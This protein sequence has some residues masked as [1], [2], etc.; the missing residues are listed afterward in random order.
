MIIS[1]LN[2]DQEVDPQIV[3]RG[4]SYYR[5]GA[6]I[7]LEQEG[8]GWRATVAGSDEYVVEVLTDKG[9]ILDYNCTCPY[10]FGPICKHEVAVFYSIRDGVKT[11]QTSR[12]K[13]VIKK[14][15]TAALTMSR[16][17]SGLLQSL[18][19]DQLVKLV[20]EWATQS[21]NIQRQICL[22]FDH[23]VPDK[24][25]LNKLI[26]QALRQAA[27]RHGFLDY[28][29]A[30]EAA[31]NVEQ[32]LN[33]ADE[34]I[35]QHNYSK[36]VPYYQATIE[37]V[38]PALQKADDSNGELGGLIEA[39]FEKLIT[40]AP[41]LPENDRQQLFTYCLNE[42]KSSEYAGWDDWQ[43]QWL[44]IAALLI[45]SADEQAQLFANID[46]LVNKNHDDTGAHFT[47]KA[48]LLKHRVINKI[49]GKAAALDFLLQ[50]QHLPTIKQK[51]IHHH[52]D[53]GDF[54][55]A[56]ALAEAAYQQ[57][58][59]TLS[60]L[61]ISFAKQLVLIAEHQNDHPALIK[62]G[63]IVFLGW[64]DFDYFVQMKHALNPQDWPAVVD[65]LLQAIDSKR[66]PRAGVA[67]KAK[68][69]YLE[70]RPADLYQLI[71]TSSEGYRL[72][73]EYESVLKADYPEGIAQ[74]YETEIYRKL[75]G[76]GLGRPVYQET[77]RLLRRIKK[78]G[79][80]EKV[81]TISAQLQKQYAN[82]PAL[83]DEL[84]RV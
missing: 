29:S 41:Q 65:D 26:K 45:T 54:N 39:S 49:Q 10:D 20:S 18:S 56:Q 71:M 42:A 19:K 84:G 67:A 58:L 74:I 35:A 48:I 61:A 1:L 64:G 72:L 51:L 43:L 4:K 30:G 77:C 78:L 38:V 76:Y 50:H 53:R 60:G 2:F 16:K 68:I 7:E 3:S 31:E 23:D 36:A 63:S 14:S 82:R 12:Q 28:W 83:L 73:S 66:H 75:K 62:W 22:R 44:R 6:V 80:K 24:K 69:L 59:T 52:I 8:A 37:V 9:V 11:A 40:L 70:N 46:E 5:K 81:A 25:T 33:E 13:R 55:Q 21:S 47:Q 17:I 57:Y 27:D 15:E 79:F 34:L 32:Y